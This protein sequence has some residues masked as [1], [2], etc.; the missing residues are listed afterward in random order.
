MAA[1]VLLPQLVGPPGMTANVV[2]AHLNK[3][4]HSCKLV[5]HACY[6]PFTLSCHVIARNGGYRR[7]VLRSCVGASTSRSRVSPHHSYCGTLQNGGRARQP[8][9]GAGTAHRVE[10]KAKCSLHAPWTTATRP[11]CGRALLHEWQPAAKQHP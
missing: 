4:D 1:A 9:E 8:G 5:I 11:P 6:D 2:N 10:R 7:A 3:A